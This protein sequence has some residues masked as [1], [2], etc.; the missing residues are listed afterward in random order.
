MN[1]LLVSLNAKYIHTNLALYSLREYA[2][3]QALDVSLFETTINWQTELII[4]EIYKKK[5]DVLGFSCYIWNISKIK[6]IAKSLKKL[7][8]ECLI[9]FGGPEVSYNPQELITGGF[10][11]TVLV[12]EG[13]RSLCE[14]LKEAT[15]TKE[16]NRKIDF[17]KISGCCFAAKEGAVLTPPS[18]PLAL[19]EIPFP[20]SSYKNL[21]D[22][23]NRII[24]YE[25]SRGCPFNCQY[26]LSGERSLNGGSVV[27]K[28]SL[29]RVFSDLQF[30][31]DNNVVRVKFVDRTFNCEKNRSLAIWK[32]LSEHDN[33]VTNFHFELAAELLD[34]EQLEFLSTVRQGLF[35]F[36][37]GVQSTNPKTLEAI[38]RITL[39]DKLTPVIRALQKNDN[40]HLHLDLIAGLP[41][42]DMSAFSRSFNYVYSLSPSQLQLGFLKLLKGSGLYDSASGYGLV[43]SDEPPY[44]ILYTVDLPYDDVLRLKMLETVLEKYY[45]SCRF[46]K[47]VSFML[48]YFNS[49]FDCFLALGEFY[50]K[51]GYHMSLHNKNEDFSILFEFFCTVCDKLEK[52]EVFKWLCLFDCFE[53]EKTKRLPDFLDNSTFIKNRRRISDF[54]ESSAMREKYLPEY[55]EYDTVQLMRMLH[56]EIFPFDPI[57]GDLREPLP[58]A[59]LF[60]YNGREPQRIPLF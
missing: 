26:C 40:I 55:A 15:D 36:E 57:E 28:L 6:A 44:E 5:P 42:E 12:G 14:L 32:F 1:A 20:Y 34:E 45:N 41:Y 37:I 3:L 4:S 13:E 19:D 23:E 35:Q 10:C 52:I 11:D 48:S 33:G 43:F 39:P 29:S 27:R 8:P 49:P 56:I 59:V 21:S 51:K 60:C 22:F 30:F 58:T 47:S 38:K 9:F 31:L 53:N 54:F 2:K 25:S 50:E 24:Y 46:K 17:S 7:L 18:P 16:K